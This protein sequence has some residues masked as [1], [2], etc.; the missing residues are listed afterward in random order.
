MRRHR[1]EFSGTP[2][3]TVSAGVP[4]SVWGGSGP[5]PPWKWRWRERRRAVRPGPSSPPSDGGQ[6]DRRRW[7][8]RWR[9]LW[10]RRPD[11]PCSSFSSPATSLSAP[12]DRRRISVWWSPQRELGPIWGGRGPGRPAQQR[13]SAVFRTAGSFSVQKC[14]ALLPSKICRLLRIP[15]PNHVLFLVLKFPKQHSSPKIQ[16]SRHEQVIMIPSFTYIIHTLPIL[17]IGETAVAV[18]STCSS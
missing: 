14:N 5:G 18:R 2:I 1:P 8:S 15:S 13:T 11:R 16:P 7:H 3:A 9:R 10:L 12:R 17:P 4:E 6:L